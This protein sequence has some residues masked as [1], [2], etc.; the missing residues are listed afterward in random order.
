[1]VF[2][3][4]VI[5]WNNGFCLDEKIERGL[6]RDMMVVFFDGIIIVEKI[7]V[8]IFINVV[9]KIGVVEVCKVVEEYNFKFCK[10]FVILNWRDVKYGK[11]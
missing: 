10:V 1:M 3:L 2:D 9:K 11:S 5:Y 7:V 8:E 4:E 6:I